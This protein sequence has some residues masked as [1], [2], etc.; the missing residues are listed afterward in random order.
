MQKS[1]I[2]ILIIGSN[3]KQKGGVADYSR[4]QS[5]LAHVPLTS[6]NMLIQGRGRVLRWIY[7]GGV[8]RHGVRI[9]DMPSN[10]TLVEGPEF[11]GTSAGGLY[12]PAAA[13]FRG[14]LF[15]KL[16]PDA[17]DLLISARHHVLILTGLY[18][19]V[20]PA[21]PIQDHQCHIDDHPNFRRFWTED[22][23]LT[24]VLVAYMKQH[25]ITHVVD[26]TAQ[27]SYR[28]LVAWERV[29]AQAQ[30]VVHCFGAQSV[31][32]E[33]LIPLGA[34]AKEMLSKATESKL[35]SI[36][37]GMFFETPYE[38]VY[39]QPSPRPPA[40]APHELER[41]RAELNVADELGRMRRCII[42]TMDTLTVSSFDQSAKGVQG[43]IRRLAAQGHLP[44]HIEDRMID[45]TR[46]RNSIEYGKT[47]QMS[48]TRLQA[49]RAEYSVIK[50]WAQKKRLTMPVECLEI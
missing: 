29:R 3:T 42:R 1:R 15:A 17:A 8:T 26:M 40:N 34:L 7:R 23:L 38:R 49:V 32:D 41:Q 31:G 10:Q 6:A 19:F 27:N 9:A 46:A 13:R 18:G 4:D 5:I 14:R 2:L 47:Y 30:V 12:L 11:G 36:Q 39:F 44:S 22:D 45:I 24:N 43:R 20:T 48:E 37:P 25:G 35:Q 50:Q 28:F 33:F 21:E 16:E